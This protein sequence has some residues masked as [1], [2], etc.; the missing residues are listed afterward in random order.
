MVVEH[1][2]GGDQSLANQRAWGR[3]YSS[4][5]RTNLDKEALEAYLVAADWAGGV[6]EWNDGIRGVEWLADT[7]KCASDASMSRRKT[8]VSVR[9]S[10]Y[11]W[12]GEIAALRTAA[13]AARKRW[14]R[15][16]E[17][18]SPEVV[19]LLNAA[20]NDA[21][22]ELKKAIKAAK[23]KAWEDLLQTID[24]DPWGKPYRM[25]MGRL[26]PAAPPITS[27][28]ET[29]VLDSVLREL[30]P[31][32]VT[33]LRGEECWRSGNSDEF[34]VI[35]REEL[36][37]AA[38]DMSLGKAPG[39]D[40][41]IGGVVRAAVDVCGDPILKTMNGLVRDGCF[42]KVWK[43]TRLVLVKKKV[44]AP[45]NR[46]SSYRP[47]CLVG[48]MGKLFERD[49]KVLLHAIEGAGLKV[50]A[51]KTEVMAFPASAFSG[52][53]RNPPRVQV[54]GVFVEVRRRLKYLGLTL[55]SG[56][57]FRPHFEEVVPKMERVVRALCRLLPNLHGPCE[58]KR[59]L[60][61]N[62]I[63][64]V[65]LY[66]VPVW[67]RAAVEDRRIRKNV[68]RVQ[69]RVALRVCCAYKTVS[70]S[71]A[72]M[73]AGIIP[74]HHL[75]P[76]LAECFWSARTADGPVTPLVRARLGM[77]ARRRA[78][79]AWRDEEL[80]LMGTGAPGERV[81]QA[82]AERLVGWTERPPSMRTSFHSTQLMTG[83]GCFLAYLCR[84]RLAINARCYHCDGAVDDATHTLV[85][86]PAW[87]EARG[88][89]TEVVGDNLTLP[90][91]V[92]TTL[93]GAVEWEAFQSFSGLVMKEKEAAERQ[94]EWEENIR[95][96]TRPPRARLRLEGGSR[97]VRRIS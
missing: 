11:W 53:R 16:R 49:L 51:N 4:W 13:N 64:S 73:L 97:K 86:C 68:G 21:R 42:P 83:H 9:R 29:G 85:I 38:K 36:Q 54:G 1:E 39:L 69:R 91:I 24:R 12:T 44:D 77:M 30:F 70:H 80:R 79:W 76:Q 95:R 37:A 10:V 52:R 47:I 33:S 61:S 15:A 84:F 46:G 25:V 50:A 55:D 78:I 23:N 45:E 89:L 87:G 43:E 57:S 27:V 35:S 5:T 88:A 81:R 14:Q 92:E 18:L 96:R 17:R 59:R 8:G 7:L 90:A 6:R 28:L 2:A 75:A 58:R 63:H 34:P 26:R 60:Y 48:E 31:C 72:M 20:R 93:G 3:R 65:L 32:P 41:I 19:D 56:W 67:W 71:A 94:R 66:G 74:L 82:L 62:V 40:G 22:K